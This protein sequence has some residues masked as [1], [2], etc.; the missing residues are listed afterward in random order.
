MSRF[1]FYPIGGTYLWVVLAALDLYR[2]PEIMEGVIRT[3]MATDFSWQAS[4]R[5][6]ER[7]YER[8]LE[9]TSE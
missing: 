3:G 2:R 6:Y 8:M 7:L 9:G 4:G 1:S 5:K